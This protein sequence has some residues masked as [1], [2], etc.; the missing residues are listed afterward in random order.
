MD[1]LITGVRTAWFNRTSSDHQEQEVI[2]HY[3]VGGMIYEKAAV[4]KAAQAGD[5]FF[6]AAAS[7]SGELVQAEVWHRKDSYGKIASQWLQTK[8]DMTRDDNLLSQPR[9]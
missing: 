6:V 8:S 3:R 5:R 2:T 1:Y 7:G 4:V 9:V